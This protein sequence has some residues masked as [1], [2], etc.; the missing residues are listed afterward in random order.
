MV[1]YGA[2]YLWPGG[3]APTL[4]ATAGAVDILLWWTDGTDMYCIGA[5]FDVK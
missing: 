5:T 4:T 3:V 1:A 2:A